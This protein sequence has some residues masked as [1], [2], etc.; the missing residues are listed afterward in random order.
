M[1]T[2]D[3]ILVNKHDYDRLTLLLYVHGMEA[4]DNMTES[5]YKSRKSLCTS[6][7]HQVT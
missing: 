4:K 7:D 3:I 1:V 2:T 6:N 5:V